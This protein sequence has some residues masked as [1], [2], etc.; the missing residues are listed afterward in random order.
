LQVKPQEVKV[1]SQVLA[2]AILNQRAPNIVGAFQQGQESGRKG[3]ARQL[4]GAVLSSGGEGIDELSTLDPELALTIG[5]QIRARNANDINDYVRDAR[6]GLASLNAN[7]VQGFL[8]FGQQRLNNLRLQGRDTTQTENIVNMVARGD[9][10]QAR[11]ILAA[12]VGVIDRSKTSSEE[13]MFANLTE[14]MSKEDVDKAKRIKLRLDAPAGTSAQ[15]RIA[16]DPTLASQV[17]GS[18]AEIQGRKTGAAELA[19][20]SA[21]ERLKPGVESLVTSAKERAKAAAKDES[22]A[23]SNQK[24]LNVYESAVSGLLEDFETASTGPIAGLIPAIGEDE[25]VLEASINIMRP[26]IKGVVREA[27]EGTFS[28]QDQELIDQLIPSRNDTDEVARR[29]IKRLDAFIRSKLSGS[30]SG[31]AVSESG[32]VVE[33]DF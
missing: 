7:D 30:D 13:R 18:Q 29:K 17:A 33:V 2:N 15:E 8:S 21:Q 6:I 4:A 3:R 11:Q 1:V 16:I 10:D 12:T 5:E 23:R 24:A 31:S 9:V 19:R 28:D 26:V 22:V 32:V 27:G 25:R 14:G 20:L